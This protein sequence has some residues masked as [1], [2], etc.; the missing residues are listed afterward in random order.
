MGWAVNST[1]NWRVRLKNNYAQ[2]AA[3]DWEVVCIQF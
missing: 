3:I 1:P 2:P